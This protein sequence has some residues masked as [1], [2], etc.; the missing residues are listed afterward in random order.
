MRQGSDER[1]SWLGGLGERTG[2]VGAF[3]FWGEQL[4][5]VV[6]LSGLASSCWSVLVV[7]EWRGAIGAGRQIAGLSQS[8]SL[9]WWSGSRRRLG[10]GDGLTSRVIQVKLVASSESG[11]P[12]RLRT[13]RRPL[14]RVRPVLTGG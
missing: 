2:R 4:A 5:L 6:G 3:V 11:T 1:G 7:W 14:S 13:E 8:L 12:K 9:S 10:R